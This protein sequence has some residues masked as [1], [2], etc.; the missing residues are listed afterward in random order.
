[1]GLV[2][3]ACAKAPEGAEGSE[4]VKSKAGGSGT[5]NVSGSPAE[6]TEAL[7]SLAKRLDRP[8]WPVKAGSEIT[9]DHSGDLAN[10]TVLDV[11]PGNWIRVRDQ[12]ASKARLGKEYWTELGAFPCEHFVVTSSVDAKGP[13]KAERPD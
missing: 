10:F 7:R 2:L 8:T 12:G 11:G 13:G 1:V 3:L 9:C 5:A 4:T 6:I